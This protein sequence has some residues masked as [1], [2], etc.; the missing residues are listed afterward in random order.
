MKLEDLIYSA[1]EHGKR[2]QL[3]EEV[4]K[5]K[6]HSTDM[7]LQEIYEEAYQTVMKT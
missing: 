7:S 3:F 2:D 5:I 6:S 4:A 1:E